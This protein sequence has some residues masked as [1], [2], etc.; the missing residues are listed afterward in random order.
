VNGYLFD[1]DVISLLAPGRVD[2]PEGFAAW[3]DEMY[4]LGQLYL[5]AVSIHML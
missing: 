5:S 1:T 2:V 4:R 3:G